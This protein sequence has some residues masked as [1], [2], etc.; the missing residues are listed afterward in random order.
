MLRKYRSRDASTNC[1]WYLCRTTTQR[2]VP[3]GELSWDPAHQGKRCRDF[4]TKP[5]KWFFGTFLPNRAIHKCQIK[6][7]G[8]CCIHRRFFQQTAVLQPPPSISTTTSRVHSPVHDDGAV[9]LAV[10]QVRGH[11]VTDARPQQRRDAPHGRQ[12]VLVH[13]VQNLPTEKTD[14]PALLIL[15]FPG[16]AI[17]SVAFSFCST[18]VHP[19]NFVHHETAHE[20]KRGSSRGSTHLLVEGQQVLELGLGQPALGRCQV[21]ERV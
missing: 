1:L 7:Q 16:S 20:I 5:E 17:R 11:L 2:F 15:L 10:R 12:V 19:M 14:T 13:V 4:S 9:R 3:I 18:D 8:Q 6:A 21:S